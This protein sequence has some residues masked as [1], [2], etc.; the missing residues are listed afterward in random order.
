M[1]CK[2]DDRD[3]GCFRVCRYALRGIPAIDPWQSQVH[4]DE[5]RQTFVRRL[6][7]AQAVSGDHPMPLLP[8]KPGYQ[9]LMI[10]VVFDHQY[11]CHNSPSSVP[12]GKR[13][14]AG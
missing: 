6:Y 13:E 12:G 4:Q 14:S 1:G 5:V 8:Q 7:S 10:F 9:F 11:Q 3:I 2:G